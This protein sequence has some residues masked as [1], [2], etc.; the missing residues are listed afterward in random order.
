MNKKLSFIIILSLIFTAFLSACGKSSSVDN[1]SSPVTSTNA[2]ASATN[3]ASNGSE[4]KQIVVGFTNW[5]RSF[6]FYVD[7]EKGLQ[8]VAD[9]ENVKLITQDPNGDLM[10][11]QQQL[12]NFITQKVDGV[13]MVPID[14]DAS[15]PSA[16]A[17]IDKGIPVVTADISIKGSKDIKSHVAS[18]N[19]FGGQLAAEYVGKIL[20]GK[21]KVAVINN[22]TITSVIER[23]DGFIETIKAKYPNIEIVAEQNGE[24]KREKALSLTENF[25]QAHPDLDAIFSVNDM[26]ALGA[27]QAVKAAKK[28]NVTIVGFD[29]TDEALKAIKDGD[30]MASVAQKP[31]EIG[32]AAME[33]LLKS[34]RGEQVETNIPVPVEIVTADNVD[35]F[36]K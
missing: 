26:M 31:I 15:L 5:S 36:L 29:A 1:S 12:E 25:L 22:P 8:E 17:V 23:S 18:D 3:N 32:K 35:Q 34:I 2:A 21:G 4:Q 13:I 16:Q 19:K 20:Q 30:H 24:S 11:Q 10:K 9:R 7:L 27:L 33:A 28:D 6:A 14:S